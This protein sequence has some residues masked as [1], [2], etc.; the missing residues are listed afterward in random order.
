MHYCNLT[1]SATYSFLLSGLSDLARARSCMCIQDA[2]A[3]DSDAC[4][5]DSDARASD[6]LVNLQLAL[7]ISVFSLYRCYDY[8]QNIWK[9]QADGAKRSEALKLG[10]QRGKKPWST[11]AT[12][13]GH[14]IDLVGGHHGSQVEKVFQF[15]RW[16]ESLGQN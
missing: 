13:S 16:S 4:A 6:D 3:S 8:L 5:S 7:L 15:R 14:A 11:L 10:G 1:V 12:C 2:C 9:I